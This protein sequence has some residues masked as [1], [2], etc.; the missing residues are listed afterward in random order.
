[1]SKGYV[2]VSI[3]LFCGC[4][5]R[6]TTDVDCDDFLTSFHEHVSDGATTAFVAS[7]GRRTKRRPPRRLAGVFAA[8]H[9]VE[10]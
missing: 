10:C 6:E 1:M 9:T 4:G 8:R 3:S 7:V 5:C 2:P